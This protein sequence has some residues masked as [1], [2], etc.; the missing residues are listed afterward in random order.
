M[1]KSCIAREQ[2]AGNSGGMRRR[3]L[4]RCTRGRAEHAL[5]ALLFFLWKEGLKA[6][7]EV[8][9]KPRRYLPGVLRVIASDLVAVVEVLT[10]SLLEG[11][12]ATQ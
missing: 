3:N 1:D 5:T 7:P 4:A 12:E 10:G 11:S 2:Q 6:N 8:E 9:G